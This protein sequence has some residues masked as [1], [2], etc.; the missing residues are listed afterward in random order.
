MPIYSQ[1]HHWTG[2]TNKKRTREAFRQG[3]GVLINVR[4]SAGTSQKA[5][6]MIQSSS[7]GAHLSCAFLITGWLRLLGLPDFHWTLSIILLLFVFMVFLRMAENLRKIKDFLQLCNFKGSFNFSLTKNL[8][9]WRVLISE[10]YPGFLSAAAG[11]RNK[12]THKNGQAF[13]QLN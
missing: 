11:W 1:I 7:V 5:V 4:N 8:D 2:T 6:I 10:S 13:Q 12:T 3:A 9:Y